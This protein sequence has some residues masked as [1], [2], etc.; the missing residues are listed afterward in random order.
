MRKTRMVPGALPSCWKL[1]LL[2]CLLWH[3]C[4]AYINKCQR[5]GPQE[6]LAGRTESAA[7]F[8][9]YVFRRFCLEVKVS[10]FQNELQGFL[11]C[12]VAHYWAEIL[13]IFRSY[14]GRNDDFKNSFWNLLTLKGWFIVKLWSQGLI[15]NVEKKELSISAC[16]FICDSLQNT[17]N[18][19][20][21]TDSYISFT[22]NLESGQKFSSNRSIRSSTYGK[23]K[24]FLFSSMR[25]GGHFCYWIFDFPQ[26]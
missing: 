21:L 7:T 17:L 4:Q 25:E 3:C 6:T 14:F 22:L 2:L 16:W 12:S 5:Q 18:T 11:L 13:T 1:T 10:K 23:K 26:N 15:L 19:S 24:Y 20:Y 8:Q 9:R